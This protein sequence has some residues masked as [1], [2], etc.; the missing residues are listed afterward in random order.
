MIII[1]NSN[2]K[3]PHYIVEYIYIYIL[4]VICTLYIIKKTVNVPN[5][6]RHTEMP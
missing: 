2:I 6:G 4:I 1:I 3:H 5:R